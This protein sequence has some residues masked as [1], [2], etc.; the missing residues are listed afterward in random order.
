M[1]RTALTKLLFLVILAF[2]LCLPEFFTVHRVLS[3]SLRCVWPR[4]R[5]AEEESAQE[6]GVVWSNSTCPEQWEHLLR[7]TA[8]QRNVTQTD[9]SCFVC[10]A[11]VN[12]PE[13]DH[14]SSSSAET[15]YFE[16]SLTLQQNN[17]A[18]VSFT[19]FGSSHDPQYLHLSDQEEGREESHNRA[20]SSLHCP[21]SVDGA[22]HSCCLLLLSNR[23]FVRGGLP[24]KRPTEGEW[25]CVLRA[26]WLSLLC[27]VLLL[28]VISVAQQITEGRKRSSDKSKI[29]L[30]QGHLIDDEVNTPM[31]LRI[32]TSGPFSCSAL[33]SIEEVETPEETETEVF[34]NDN[35]DNDHN[36]NVHHRNSRATSVRRPEQTMTTTEPS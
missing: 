5:G 22:N 1:T 33:S 20:S 19:L 29:H 24:W 17:T 36:G 6:T 34:F 30:S 3:V 14:N 15:V 25:R 4:L 11:N 8:D 28:I 12:M 35:V 23:T 13:L 18:S 10:Q 31:V 7:A 9:R 26:T 2:I 27:V 16:V 21:P 32:D